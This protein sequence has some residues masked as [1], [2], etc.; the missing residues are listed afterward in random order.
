[1]ETVRLTTRSLQHC[2]SRLT[3]F[4]GRD[5]RELFWPFALLNLAGT[6]VAVAV[7]FAVLLSGSFEAI[8][9]Y[10]EAN[11]DKVT[12][13]RGPGSVSVRF[14]E[15]PP[16]LMPD[17]GDFLLP[18]LAIGLVFIALHAAAVARRLHD[19]G[20]P[21]WLGAVPALLF[22]AA[23]AVMFELFGAADRSAEPGPGLFLGG[24]ALNALYN[25]SLIAL[26]LVLAL[27]GEAA[28]NRYGERPQLPE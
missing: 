13:M 28:P 19:L 26:G 9:A 7:V 17:M 10:A 27:K 22:C 20:R 14:D 2:W 16:G 25:L 12:V 1:M 11:P 24:F 23:F 15:A 4:S 6:F 21:G 8:A 18:M 5:R 3:D